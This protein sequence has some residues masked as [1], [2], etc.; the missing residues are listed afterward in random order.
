MGMDSELATW[1]AHLFSMTPTNACQVVDVDERLS[2]R[3]KVGFFGGGARTAS[4]SGHSAKVRERLDV[5]PRRAHNANA[6]VSE[7]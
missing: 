3:H 5:G 4:L 2:K 1:M 6:R 7:H